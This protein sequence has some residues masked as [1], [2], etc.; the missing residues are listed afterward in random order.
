MWVTRWRREEH[1]AVGILLSHRS[2]NGS[3]EGGGFSSSTT[4]ERHVAAPFFFDD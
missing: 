3:G 1:P 4:K 2:R